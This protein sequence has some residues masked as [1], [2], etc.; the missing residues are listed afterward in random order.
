VNSRHAKDSYQLDGVIYRLEQ[1]DL[2]TWRVYGGSK[3][4]GEVTEMLLHDV[5][6]EYHA[7]LAGGREGITQ[8][9]TD[10]WGTA[11]EFLIAPY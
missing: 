6:V 11:V 2:H 5:S 3:L 9:S 8:V 4:L 7:R 1:P 10:V